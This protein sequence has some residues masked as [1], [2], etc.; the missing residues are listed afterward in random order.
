MDE[1]LYTSE[2]VAKRYRVHPKTVARW[3]RA[4]RLGGI[5]LSA[6]S[7]GEYRFTRQDMEAFEA[8][9]REREA[10]A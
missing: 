2:E 10:S 6:A 7:N 1:K 8:R 3:V 4:G 5:K 9:C